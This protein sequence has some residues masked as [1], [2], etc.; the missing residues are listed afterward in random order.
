MPSLDN[1]VS[2][3]FSLQELNDCFSSS[4]TSLTEILFKVFTLIFSEAGFNKEE[5]SLIASSSP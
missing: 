1:L 4:T 3:I 5:P 2:T